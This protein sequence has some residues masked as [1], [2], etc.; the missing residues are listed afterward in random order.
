MMFKIFSVLCLFHT[1]IISLTYSSKDIHSDVSNNDLQNWNYYNTF[2]QIKNL[3]GLE[4]VKNFSKRSTN[5]IHRQPRQRLDVSSSIWNDVRQMYGTNDKNKISVPKRKPDR[6]IQDVKITEHREYFSPKDKPLTYQNSI[7]QQN[8]IHRRNYDDFTY[9]KSNMNNHDPEKDTSFK[10]VEENMDKYRLRKNA[11]KRY[12]PTKPHK[13][14]PRDKPLN[15]RIPNYL[16]DDYY[17]DQENDD[18]FWG[19][20]DYDSGEINDWEK[21]TTRNKFNMGTRYNGNN[22]RKRHNRHKYNVVIDDSLIDRYIGPLIGSHVVTTSIHPWIFPYFF[23]IAEPYISFI[24]FVITALI[25]L[26]GIGVGSAGLL[27]GLRAFRLSEGN[28]G[29]STTGINK[30]NC[31]F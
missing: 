8:N 16:N 7:Y 27:V 21:E 20:D 6:I 30:H 2:V 15:N 18:Y 26:F 1:N 12:Q 31:Y 22:F 5:K 25:E 4:N 24:T 11:L 29:A 23:G 28:D 10:E 13:T 19:I 9:Y 14:N 17:Y 3:Y